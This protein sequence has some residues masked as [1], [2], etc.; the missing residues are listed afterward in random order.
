MR[1]KRSLVAGAVD[2]VDRGGDIE[3]RK[4]I[5]ALDITGRH[6]VRGV[7]VSN[8]VRSTRGTCA[9]PKRT[10]RFSNPF[11]DTSVE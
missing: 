8:D 3:F 9:G 10:G 6:N 1:R 2:L 11:A 7:T 5:S 4:R